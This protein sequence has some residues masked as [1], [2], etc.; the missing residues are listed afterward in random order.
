MQ[1]HKPI[2]FVCNITQVSS[3]VVPAN[4]SKDLQ[5]VQ[6]K[7]SKKQSKKKVKNKKRKS[8]KEKVIRVSAVKL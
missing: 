1:I 7:K 2:E 6:A 3:D 8:K 4:H 5:G